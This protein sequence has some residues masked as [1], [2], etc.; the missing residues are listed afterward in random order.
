MRKVK[1]SFLTLSE[2]PIDIILLDEQMPFMNGS[3]CCKILKDIIREQGLN[4][5]RI[6]STSTLNNDQMVEYK[7]NFGFD[8]FIAKPVNVAK[9]TQELYIFK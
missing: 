1:L 3:K 5:I 8:G 9:L 6:Y 4:K 2:K 7:L